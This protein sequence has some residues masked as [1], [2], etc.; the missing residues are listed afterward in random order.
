MPPVHCSTSSGSVPGWPGVWEWRRSSRV[1]TR[2]PPT[3]G[4][5]HIVQDTSCLIQYSDDMPLCCSHQSVTQTRST[6]MTTRWGT[7]TEMA[8]AFTESSRTRPATREQKQDSL[9][10]SEWAGTRSSLRNSLIEIVVLI[11]MNEK[12]FW[13]D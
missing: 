13:L 11:R 1:S 2:N 4:F 3:K 8:W 12:A 10:T 5:W 9:F 7:R 6:C